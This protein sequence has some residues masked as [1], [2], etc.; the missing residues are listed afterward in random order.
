M[1]LIA[2]F[3]G[4]LGSFSWFFF[5]FLCD[6]LEEMDDPSVD[7]YALYASASHQ[8]GSQSYP[9]TSKQ[10]EYE[11]VDDAASVTY[12]AVSPVARAPATQAAPPVPPMVDSFVEDSDVC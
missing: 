7:C 3:K 1:A 4:S 10:N 9:H 2:S 8:H 5:E 12:A 11:A 6:L